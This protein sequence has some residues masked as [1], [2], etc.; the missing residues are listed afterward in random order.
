MLLS[1]RHQ[2]HT[3]M[4]KMSLAPPTSWLRSVLEWWRRWPAAG[5]P[6]AEDK[7]VPIREVASAEPVGSDAER[8]EIANT[9]ST[10]VAKRAIKKAAWLFFLS[11]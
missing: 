6:A 9:G 5:G 4:L 8:G 1:D 10:W 7:A 11:V 3:Q 2:T